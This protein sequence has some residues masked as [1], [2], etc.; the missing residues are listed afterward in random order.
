MPGRD[1]GEGV[2]GKN[3]IGERV[4]TEGDEVKTEVEPSSRTTG[5]KALMFMTATA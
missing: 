3:V 2:I 5:T 1:V 4:F